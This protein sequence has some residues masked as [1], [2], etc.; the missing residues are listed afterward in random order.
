VASTTGFVAPLAALDPAQLA[1]H[2]P[3][4]E[5]L[6]LL[7]RGGMGAVYRARQTRLDRL[8]A[9][10]VLPPEAGRDP[11]FAARFG[12]EARTLARLSHPHVVGVHDFGEAD[13]L[14]YL[15]MEHVD[16]G[17]LRQRMRTGRLSPGEALA[18]ARQICE[19][20]EYAHEAGVAHRDI[21]PENILLDKKGR[22]KV[23]D[24]GLAKLL[25]PVPAEPQLTASHQ[26]VGTLK[27]MAPEQLERPLEVDHRADLYSLGVVLYEMLTG[28]LPFG[29]FSL[30][31]EKDVG[32]SLL[33][34][35]ILR[36]LER[37]PARRFQSAGEMGAALAAVS[38]RPAAGALTQVPVAVPSPVS[39]GKPTETYAVSRPVASRDGKGLLRNKS[40]WGF[41]FCLVGAAACFQP[42]FPWAELQVIDNEGNA[43]DLAAVYGFESI[44]VLAVG[45]IFLTVW[46]V[47]LATGFSEPPSRWQSALF[48]V[49]GFCVMLVTGSLSLITDSQ[50]PPG[51]HGSAKKNRE[52]GEKKGGN[53]KG[54]PARTTIGGSASISVL[55]KTF[56][57][58]YQGSFWGSN[59]EGSFQ[60]DRKEEVKVRH[61]HL[62]TF[63]ASNPLGPLRV[64]L[65]AWPYVVLILGFALISVGCLQ[66]RGALRRRHP[67]P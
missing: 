34:A 64:K 38:E 10:K 22:V 6:G 24:F 5:I 31:S 12:R 4:L 52:E 16:G 49:V 65:L 7:G 26:I 25:G 33:D 35:V 37:D 3:Q 19:A 28:E 30:P 1:P 9:L 11:T 2:L 45:A 14:Y 23:A 39:S 54:D 17:N 61:Y 8:I 21:K 46:F 55:G 41:L 13:G 42:F 56:N 43:I 29:R 60:V 47:F 67:G 51:F 27:Y 57:V 18:V 44:M 15:L 20:L 53:G 58:N 32:D 48:I 40:V 59:S 36:A 62:K 50:S 63:S 66:I